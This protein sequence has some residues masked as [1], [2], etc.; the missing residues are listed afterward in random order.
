MNTTVTSTELLAGL[1]DAHN[2]S[3]W[4]Q[5]CARYEPIL[6]ACAGRAGLQQAD[7]HDVVQET[8]LTFVERFR[9]GDYDRERGRLRAW[10]RGIAANKIH[11]V[12]RQRPRQEVQAADQTGSTQLLQRV[13]DEAELA[14]DFEAEWERSVLAECLRLVREQV[15]VLTFESFR[16]YALEDR[17]VE[18]V[19]ARLGITREAVYVHKSRVLKRLRGWRQHIGDDW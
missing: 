6:L 3:A 15:D 8:L 9:A 17:P 1:R 18:E 19:A 11:E 2:K 4:R 16:L 13:P 12:R 14:D 7:A 5:L 10:L